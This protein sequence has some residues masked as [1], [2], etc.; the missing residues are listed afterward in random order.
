MSRPRDTDFIL[1]PPPEVWAGGCRP[2]PVAQGPGLLPFRFGTMGP[3][4]HRVL[5]A[6][7]IC[8]QACWGPREHLGGD[9]TGTPEG[10]RGPV[11]VPL[12]NIVTRP[13]PASGGAEECH[14]GGPGPAG[15]GAPG[16]VLS[17]RVLPAAAPCQVLGR[18]PVAVA[19]G[20][21]ACRSHALSCS[22]SKSENICP[23]RFFFIWRQC[24]LLKVQLRAGQRKGG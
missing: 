20:R 22:Q 6:G 16:K 9:H 24:R 13:P 2:P 7:H 11:G 3:W 8:T 1:R 23:S 4:P 21:V 12:G 14:A 5:E 10:L 17:L 15:W 19:S 18:T